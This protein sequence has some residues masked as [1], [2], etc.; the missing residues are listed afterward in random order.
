MVTGKYRR[1][2]LKHEMFSLGLSVLVPVLGVLLLGW[3]AH[4]IMFIVSFEAILLS[5]SLM[6][7]FNYPERPTWKGILLVIVTFP[8]GLLLMI[9]LNE[10]YNDW[11]YRSTDMVRDLII[12]SWPSLLITAI[13]MAQTLRNKMR[14]A[15]QEGASIENNNRI[16]LKWL[17]KVF[18]LFAVFTWIF[19]GWSRLDGWSLAAILLVKALIDMSFFYF[20]NGSE[21]R[22]SRVPE[23][24]VE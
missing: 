16:L 22:Q 9:V 7:L 10:T 5:A 21:I 14:T 23:D 3:D 4:A 24:V 6:W 12:I 1:N 2:H 11:T 19:V 20:D 17:F 18:I 8:A 15:Q 13:T